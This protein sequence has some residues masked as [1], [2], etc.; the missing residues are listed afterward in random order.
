MGRRGLGT[1]W[2]AYGS[3][4][5]HSVPFHFQGLPLNRFP[6]A[7][8]LLRYTLCQVQSEFNV[9]MTEQIASNPDSKKPLATKHIAVCVF[10]A[11]GL[12]A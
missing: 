6:V 8:S 12:K 11:N 2:R 5:R 10:G 7:W 9:K 3:G 4:S 1:H